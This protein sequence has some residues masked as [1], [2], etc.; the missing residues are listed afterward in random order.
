MGLD[1]MG[2]DGMG[3]MATLLTTA[4]RLAAPVTRVSVMTMVCVVTVMIGLDHFHIVVTLA[5][6]LQKVEQSSGGDLGSGRHRHRQH[7]PGCDGVQ[8]AVPSGLVT[9]DGFEG[10]GHRHLPATP[11]TDRDPAWVDHSPRFPYRHNRQSRLN[12][13]IRIFQTRLARPLAVR[14]TR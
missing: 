6:P 13:I 5:D 12:P 4:I 9:T 2:L 14:G 8:P 3:L 11:L 1:G 10:R 7:Q